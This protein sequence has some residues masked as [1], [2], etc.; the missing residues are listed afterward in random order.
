ML[1]GLS[2]LTGG[3]KNSR[4][5]FTIAGNIKGTKSGKVILSYFD[6]G[7]NS[8]IEPDTA[9]IANGKFGLQ[10]NLS[11]PRLTGLNTESDETEQ[12]LQ[13]SFFAENAHIK[14]DLDTSQYLSK[15]GHY[16]ELTPLVKGCPVQ[17][18]YA[19][20][21]SE[22]RTKTRAI[23]QRYDELDARYRNKV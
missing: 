5:G 23:E 12:H 15:R 17:D 2:V 11:S 9:E 21:L 3:C 22:A 6:V 8:R 13:C 16:V 1:A 19:T 18:E 10:G 20:Y 14:I 4:H 7:E